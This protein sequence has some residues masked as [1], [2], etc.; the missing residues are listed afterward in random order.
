MNNSNEHIF[1]GIHV[2]GEL[3]EINSTLLNDQDFLLKS[4]I[5]GVQESGAH[6]EGI[7]TKK[8]EPVGLSMIFLL[9]ESHTSIHT[10]PEKKALFIDAF[11][12]GENCNPTKIIEVI[13][14]TLKVK[15]YSIKKEIRGLKY[16]EQ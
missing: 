14:D 6:I 13:V 9:S 5:K 3:Y 10:Y 15:K 8:F 7:L 2:F 4:L 11:T 1:K 16:E 12:C